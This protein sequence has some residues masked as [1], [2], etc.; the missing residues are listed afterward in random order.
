MTEVMFTS[1]AEASVAEGL[2]G[3]LTDRVTLA[4]FVPAAIFWAGGVATLLLNG[5]AGLWGW[6][7][8]NLA[9]D[10]TGLQNEILKQFNLSGV[11]QYLLVIGIVF[12]SALAVDRFVL[13]ALQWTEGYLPTW[14]TSVRQALVK[15]RQRQLERDR[16]TYDRLA[17]KYKRHS[18]AERSEYWELN[19]RLE[20]RTPGTARDLM[21]TE[22]GNIL[23]AAETRPK[24]KYGLDVIVCWPRL[25]LVL[26]ES[27]T[28]ELAAARAN[29]DTA[30]RIGL[31]GGLFLVWSIWVWWAVP[32]AVLVIF[33][34]YRSAV[35]AAVSYGNFIESA[36]D[37]YRM[38]LYEKAG[39]S[40]PGKLLAEEIAHGEAL[41][42]YFWR[43]PSRILLVTE[44][45]AESQK[46]LDTPNS[47]Q[48]FPVATGPI[49]DSGDPRA[50]LRHGGG[51]G[52]S[53]P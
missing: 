4:L 26:P 12:L 7:L 44:K 51:I 41:T 33:L 42:S 39:W 16:R 38:T 21:P 37:M 36:F 10:V 24:D 9:V 14:L 5:H 15:R 29:L 2:G 45:P 34:A 1:V 8:A 11:K 3:R 28:K 22:L 50:G 49:P 30:I 25:W 17:A 40:P 6:G 35:G 31:W 23:R 27:A 19:R 18:D 46:T 13:P 48:L 32:V 43:R 53:E 47:G 52:W 20:L